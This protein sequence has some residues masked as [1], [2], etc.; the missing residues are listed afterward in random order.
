LDKA[1]FRS[2]AGINAMII[3]IIIAIRRQKMCLVM[4]SRSIKVLTSTMEKIM[5]RCNINEE[6]DDDDGGGGIVFSKG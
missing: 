2:S 5:M 3:I 1:I 4:I 6:E